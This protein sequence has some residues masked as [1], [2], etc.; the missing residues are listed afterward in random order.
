MMFRWRAALLAPLFAPLAIAALAAIVFPPSAHPVASVLVFFIPSLFVAYATMFL[1]FLPALWLLSRVITPTGGRVAALGLALGALWMPVVIW[2]MWRSSGLDSG[3]QD[4]P[5]SDFL[6]NWLLDPGTAIF[7]V[8]P[9][10]GLITA[11][12]YWRLARTPAP[13]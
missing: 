2:Q 4:K 5:L 8:L 3:P 9:V 10:A 7:L 11:I 13:A 12:A 1:M 6:A